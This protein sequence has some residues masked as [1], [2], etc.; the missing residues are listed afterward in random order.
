[1]LRNILLLT[2]G[3]V[4]A[5]QAALADSYKIDPVHSQIHFTVAHLVVFKVRGEFN[6]FSGEVDANPADQSLQSAK[7]MIRVASIDTRNEKRNKHL[8]SADF[9][10]ASNHPQMSFESTRVEGSGD[11]ITVHG[12]LTIRGNTRE[13]VLTGKFLGAAK[14]PNGNLRAGFEA[15]GKINRH[16]FGL[17]WNKALETGGFVVGDDVEIGI[18]VEAVKI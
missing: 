5:S 16:D 18:E 4:F 1:M 11:S 15:S 6:E 10:D 12:N 13:V 8:R 7:A 17:S 3:L 14:D 2:I 9:F